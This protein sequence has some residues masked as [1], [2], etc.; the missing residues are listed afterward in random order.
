[1]T[2]PPTARHFFAGIDWA[3]KTHAVCV[4]DGRG[5]IRARFEIA[6]TGKTFTGLVKRLTKWASTVWRSNAVT[7]RWSRRC[8]TPT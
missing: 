8:W 4:V 7:A 5:E 6:N 2:A 3:S 1:M